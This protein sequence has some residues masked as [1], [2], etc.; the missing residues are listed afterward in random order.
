MFKAENL[1]VGYGEA[2]ALRDI[3]I[4]V[5]QGEIVTIIG[6][7]GAGKTTLVN[8]IAG[9]LR[10]REGKIMLN[11]HDISTLAAHNVIDRGVVIVPEGRRL[12]TKLTV[13][14]NLMLGAYTERARSR[15]DATLKRVYE[16]FPRLSER[17]GQLAGTLS[18]G[19]Q[20]MLAIGRALLAQPQLLLLDEPSLGLAPI[21][22]T[23]I[24]DVIEQINREEG[25]TI[26]L[27]EQNANKALATANR[28]YILSDGKIVT[29]GTPDQLSRDD[30]VRRAY[31]GLH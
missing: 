24:F 31:L 29:E 12:F 28:A 23:E 9:I 19:E 7:N 11:G 30:S 6:A 5:D 3:N 25:V 8:T 13:L 2:I 27:V 17:R 20:Q 4:S 16:I 26:L 1:T 18:G 21:I 15:K 10:P 14:D 22:V